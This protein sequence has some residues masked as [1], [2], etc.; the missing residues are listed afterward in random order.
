M[1]RV[2]SLFSGIGAFEQA[3]S[4]LHIDFQIV[5]FCEVD[6]YATKAY[7]LLHDIDKNKN[8]GDITKIDF[9]KLPKDIDLI[10]Y[11]FPCQD[12]SIAGKMQGLKDEKGNATRSGLLYNAFEIIK[13]IKPK[14]AIFENVKNLVSNKFAG[15]FNEYINKLSEIGYDSV[16]TILNA[17]DFGL[18]QNR[19][20]VFCL[21]IL[22]DL[23]DYHFR[24]KEDY[25]NKFMSVQPKPLNK[26]LKDIL[27]DK[28]DEKYYINNDRVEIFI[29]NIKNYK[30][31]LNNIEKL[32]MQNRKSLNLCTRNVNRIGG[33][34]DND[35]RHQAGSVYDINGLAPTLDTMQGGYRQ[36]LILLNNKIRK[37]TPTECFR[38]MGFN[39]KTKPVR[40]VLESMSDTQLYKMA[41]N[42]IAVNVLEGIFDNLFHV[43]RRYYF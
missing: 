1:L 40:K 18:P 29:Q 32:E 17:K 13:H 28:V 3:L 27:E 11:G 16:Y 4:N 21:S 19:E 15:D 2:L 43:L 8:L 35:S 30:N 22:S 6:K 5:N 10:T 14:M 9:N 38:L 37:L 36:P 24:S 39:D 34:F 26:A 12:I 42:S 31:E 7:C 41:G 23:K 20:R 25:L 33:L